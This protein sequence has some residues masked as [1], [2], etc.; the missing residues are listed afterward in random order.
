MSPSWHESLYAPTVHGADL[1][2]EL[3]ER[4]RALGFV[5]VGIAAAAP[6]TDE[7]EHLRAWLAA[8]RHG[9]MAWMERTADVRLDPTADGMLPSAATVIV[10]VAPYARQ[11]ERVGPAPLR[12]A[13][14][15]RGR[16]Y[17]NVL[18]KRLRKLAR[19]LRD[20]GHDVRAAVDSMPVF[21]RAWAERAGVG[22]VGKNSCLIVPGL[23]S[24]VFLAALVTSAPLPPDEPMA[25]RC[26][27]C[28]LCLDVCP[29]D[30]FVGAR[31]LDAR[32]CI[33]YLTIEHDGPIDLELR[34][35]LGDWVFGCDACQDICPF[36]RTSPPDEETT[37]PFAPH[38]RFATSAEELLRMDAETYLDWS[39]G[40]P[41]R[42]TG[43]ERMARNVVLGL[44]NSGDRR[45]LPILRDVAA[46]D[47][48]ETV[49][50]AAAW[51]LGR[52]DP[53]DD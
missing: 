28:R 43:R 37:A 52:L 51:S 4:G 3:R 49:R 6:L 24:H 8:E 16:D 19:F 14:Y 7:A 42:R 13:R 31:E 41:L 21:E 36:N 11:V 23:G 47:A 15:A 20:E 38:R 26:G 33:S 32:R 44:G 29:T 12:V 35:G 5:R 30:A 46:D 50:E 22:F 27:S 17:H 2:H 1:A 45:H 9:Q 48:S 18:H 39:E 10:L 40:S 34:E 25:T 53:P